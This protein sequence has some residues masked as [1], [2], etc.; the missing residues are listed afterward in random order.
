MRLERD[1]ALAA[2]Q[3][4]KSE[5]LTLGNRLARVETKLT[6]SQ[7][8]RSGDQSSP[9]FEVMLKLLAMACRRKPVKAQLDIQHW[10]STAKA[11]ARWLS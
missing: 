10:R 1:Q 4:Y 8:A 5:A 9:R 3:L 7:A 2:A 6:R 11:D